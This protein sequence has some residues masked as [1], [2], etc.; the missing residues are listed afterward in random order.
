MWGEKMMDV[1][2]ENFL[3]EQSP[4]YAGSQLF[5]AHHRTQNLRP[6]S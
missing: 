4:Q 6:G 5:G 2:G 1:G 3:P